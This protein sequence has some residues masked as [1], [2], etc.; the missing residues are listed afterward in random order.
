MLESKCVGWFRKRTNY[1]GTNICIHDQLRVSIIAASA[2]SLLRGISNGCSH[3]RVIALLSK[4]K[5]N[6]PDSAQ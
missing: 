4:S 1:S 3:A 2:I 5:W 6:C